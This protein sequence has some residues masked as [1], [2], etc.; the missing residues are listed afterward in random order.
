MRN[1]LIRLINILLLMFGFLFSNTQT[2]LNGSIEYFYMT[3]LTDFSVI[4]IP[5]R[6]LDFHVQHQN[7]NVDVIANLS[8]EYRSKKDT[9]FLVDSDLEDF[10]MDIRELYL[11]YYLK[12]GEVRVGKQIHSWG[13]V[14]ENSPIDNLNAYDYYYLLLGGSEK[15][16]GSYSMAIDYYFLEHSNLKLSYVFSPMHNT[17]RFPVND[18]EYPIG[19][20]EEANPSDA[21]L[22]L[23]DSRPYESSVNLRYSFNFG[24][25]SFSHLYMYDR[26][27]NLTGVNVYT[28]TSG[29]LF[30]AVPLYSYRLTKAYSLGGVFL[31]DDFT[32]RFDVTR[33]NSKDQN[34]QDDLDIPHPDPDKAALYSELALDPI[35]LQES[36]KYYQ[37]AIQLE[38]PLENNYSISTLYFK[39]DLI[40]YS[41]NPLPIDEDID[42]P[43][44][45]IDIDSFSPEAL[46][47]P[48]VGIPHTTLTNEAFFIEL[49][50]TLLD[51]NLSITLTSFFDL[52]KGDGKLASFETEYSFSNGLKISGGIT[53]INGQRDLENYSFNSM[54]DFSHFRCQIKYYF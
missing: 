6:A 41:Y 44:L 43:N 50:K 8:L 51:D 12:N 10:S 26:I 31:F 11:G 28:N 16:L 54:E 30:E 17:S 36:A 22:I 14:D 1:N 13:N 27:F 46:F 15:K 21:T 32:L 2:Q 3:R 19:L 37:T 23:N 4:N 42:I 20:P 49:K 45:D 33:F 40:E 38:M 7:G 34:N 18:P 47:L 53:N 52:D 35:V 25:I 48:G 9:D 5:F 29:I 24:D 39:H